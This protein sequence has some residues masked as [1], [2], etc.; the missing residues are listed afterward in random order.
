[1]TKKKPKSIS[2]FKDALTA[3]SEVVKVARIADTPSE[4]RLEKILKDH[5]KVALIEAHCGIG[6]SIGSIAAIIGVYDFQLED[7]I[8][9][10]RKECQ[11][12]DPEVLQT[13]YMRLWLLMSVKWAEARILAEN[14]LKEKNPEK[15]LQSRTAKLLGD[16]W[17]ENTNKDS[18][19]EA[20]YIDVGGQILESLRSLR[21]Q[22]FDLN[23]II[24]K[25][26]LTLKVDAPPKK[27]SDILRE[28]GLLPA[29]VRSSLP[30]FFEPEIPTE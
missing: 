23:D 22:G 3:V 27:D 12:Y 2:P 10:G 24:D 20:M 28:N 15:Y 6:A 11:E 4:I 8:L 21:N 7:W 16:D 9:R 25:D 5:H 1:M 26:K 18:Q 13:P 19:E 17:V 30:K 14:A 29:P